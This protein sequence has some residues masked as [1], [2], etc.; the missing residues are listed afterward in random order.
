MWEGVITKDVEDL[1]GKHE[2]LIE[3]AEQ[4]SYVTGWY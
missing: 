1:I 3:K 2:Q 4:L